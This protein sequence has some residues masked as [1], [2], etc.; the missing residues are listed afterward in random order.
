MT[1]ASLCLVILAA[2]AQPPPPTAQTQPPPATATIRGR[3]IAGDTGLPLRKAEVQLNQIDAQT[4]A[5]TGARRENRTATTDADGKYEFRDLPGG[6]YFVHAAKPPYVNVSWG[7]QQA[8]TPMK[9]IDL[10]S[11]ET[12]DRVDFTLARGGVITGRIVD[13]FGEPLSG[14]QVNAML[15]QTI[16]GARQLML[17]TGASTDDLGEFRIFGITPGQYYV[18]AAWQRMGAGD[19][20][21]P[22]RTGYPVTFFP[23]T[24]NEAEARRFTV[25]AGQTI[26]DVSMA[27][28]PI[29]TVRVEG[30]V[31]DVNGRPMGN[32]FLEVLRSS[33]HNS[34][35]TRHYVQ[36]DGTFT[37]ASLT[38]AD[39]TFRT[40][41][42]PTR[43][44]VAMMKLTVGSEDIKGLRLV[45]LPPAI[46]SGRIVVDPSMPLPAAALSIRAT[47][48]AQR[49]PG[50]TTPAIVA[51]DLTFELTAMP[52]RNRLTIMNLPAGWTMRSV[53]VNSVEV[54]DDGI[55]VEPGEQITGVDVELS[56][57]ITSVSGRVTNARGEPVRECTLIVFA[58]DNKRWKIQGRYLRTARPD[59][60]G[61]FKVSGLA[62]SDYY[63][64]AIDK[65]EPGQGLDAEF[66]E[67]IR[68]KATSVSVDDGET[69]SVDLKINTAS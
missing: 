20:S 36:P 44:E 7:Q 67:R 22:D 8:N 9:P 28:S 55:D 29:R 15:T 13:E 6:R 38:P 12:L 34:S 54:I 24:T 40:Q 42:T 62:P 49:M 63:I 58:T 57:K 35:M 50:G 26:S 59:Q 51:D 1:P 5:T 25:S 60:D 27:L 48:E 30:T 18:Q 52:G 64:V 10:R 41:P 14:A 17:G 2:W 19:P 32:T 69:R 53:R 33:G 39:Y 43:K 11:G 4:A 37:F 47:P 65:L 45:A 31:V 3:V 46:V 68:S 16:N 66:L 61:R 23:G 21:S 56:D